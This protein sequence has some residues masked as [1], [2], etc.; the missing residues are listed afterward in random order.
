[1]TE[2][3]QYVQDTAKTSRKMDRRLKDL[4]VCLTWIVK[5][6]TKKD[7]N[8]GHA[9][10]E[11]IES[12][13]IAASSVYGEADLERLLE[14]SGSVLSLSLGELTEESVGARWQPCQ[15]S[16]VPA[17]LTYSAFRRGPV[18]PDISGH[19]QP[20]TVIRPPSRRERP[21]S[22]LEATQ[23]LANSGPQSAPLIVAGE[24]L[25]SHM[26]THQRSPSPSGLNT[27]LASDS[28][29]ISSSL[30]TATQFVGMVTAPTTPQPT[31]HL[32][33]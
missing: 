32:P 8:C 30:M 24:K 4:H 11:Q 13:V 18:L 19:P 3:Y 22:L 16:P 25:S 2:V 21:L 12:S 7:G 27:T 9:T 29:N 17:K 5:Q 6:A 33:N 28:V 10:A 23:T 1:M 14:S 26:K 20:T 31:G 15:T